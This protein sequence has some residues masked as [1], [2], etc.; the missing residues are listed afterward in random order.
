MVDEVQIYLVLATAF[1][2]PVVMSIVS[3]FKREGAVDTKTALAD[4]NLISLQKDLLEL[5]GDVKDLLKSSQEMYSFKARMEI[6]EQ[7]SRSYDQLDKD[8]GIVKVRLSNLETRS[9]GRGPP[10]YTVNDTPSG[11]RNLDSE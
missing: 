5:K 9:S 8:F 7:K 4:L 10:R 2:V 1:A 3:Y 11:D 6:L